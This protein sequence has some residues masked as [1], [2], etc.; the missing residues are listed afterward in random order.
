MLPPLRLDSIRSDL[1]SQRSHRVADADHFSKFVPEFVHFS[2]FL[3]V[4]CYL[5]ACVL[6]VY[7]LFTKN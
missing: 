6:C 1:N 2:A 4:W 3:C 7:V 5:T